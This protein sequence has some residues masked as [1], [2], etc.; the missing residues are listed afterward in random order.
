M[1]NL[2]VMSVVIILVFAV[3]FVNSCVYEENENKTDM[4]SSEKIFNNYIK[5][6]FAE[7]D[8]YVYA[9]TNRSLKVID[10]KTS[11]V[12]MLFSN[13]KENCSL[14]NMILTK[15]YIYFIQFSNDYSDKKL[16]CL[17]KE[18][19]TFEVIF[20]F[21]N[22]PFSCID[23]QLF[24]NNNI[25]FIENSKFIAAFKLNADGAVV[26]NINKYESSY[27]KLADNLENF[28][29]IDKKSFVLTPDVWI[30]NKRLAFC[31]EANTNKIIIYDFQNKAVDENLIFTLK[32][33]DLSTYKY[34]FN[35]FDSWSR[36]ENFQLYALRNATIIAKIYKDNE[37]PK[38]YKLDLL[39]KKGS[40]MF[41]GEYNFITSKENCI[42][43]ESCDSK[44]QYP[45]K[46]DVFSYDLSKNDMDINKI[47]TYEKN[48]Y[49]SN[50]Y[51]NGFEKLS[52][53]NNSVYYFGVDD[54]RPCIMS[55]TY[56][57]FE[58]V[59][60]IDEE[61]K[62]QAI[63][64]FG[65]IIR[66]KNSLSSTYDEK[67]KY[68]HIDLYKF[69]FNE[70]VSNYRIMN[71][72][73]DNYY[74]KLYLQNLNEAKTLDVLIK[75]DEDLDY[76]DYNTCLYKFDLNNILITEDESNIYLNF[77]IYMYK[78]HE[79]ENRENVQIVFDKRTGK[80]NN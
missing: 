11:K 56:G 22:T 18:K 72:Y 63:D 8:K 65:H 31:E 20:D 76:F 71:K 75:S 19:K 4:I 25:L 73:L 17:S 7:S 13:D 61:S 64:K 55:R 62:N 58:K 54:F 38:F 69:F 52:F 48:Y 50:K 33:E 43:L 74:N 68:A 46:S 66:Q 40:F 67:I 10:K 3:I 57:D 44:N 45:D 47:F 15:K 35:S 36:R 49:L 12:S 42:Y 1:Y 14:E 79:I 2:K 37:K 41:E 6:N 29:F 23:A 80:S 78:I 51:G 59:N 60:L 5:S 9:L 27:A 32:D 39:N 28:V 70:S 34:D 26:E 21:T 77:D 16:I 30:D 53:L 24:L